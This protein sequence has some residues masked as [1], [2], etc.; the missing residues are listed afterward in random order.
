MLVGVEGVLVGAL[1][2][3]GEVGE[4]GEV[5]GTDV[6][7]AAVVGGGTVDEVVAGAL[8]W[9]PLGSEGA[10]PPAITTAS[11]TRPATLRRRPE[12]NTPSA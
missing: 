6:V 7:G 3:V 12:R 1:G 10:Q 11:A 5:E 2:V 4:V 8:V 9:L